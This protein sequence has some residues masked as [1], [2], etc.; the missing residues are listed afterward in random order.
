MSE[1]K[2]ILICANHEEEYPTPLISTL[3]F[4]GAEKWCPFCGET[5]DIFYGERVPS[6]P[7]LEQRKEKY[8]KASDEYLDAIGN[9]SCSSL[10]WE[11]K[12]ISPKDLPFTEKERCQNIVSKGWKINIKAED[13][14]LA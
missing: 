9:L 10:M 6:T 7:E 2:T 4:R 8:K 3:V 12:R 1:Q 14:I 13:I 11:G 5:G